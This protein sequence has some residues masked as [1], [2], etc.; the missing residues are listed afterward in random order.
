[1]LS[2]SEIKTLPDFSNHAE[3]IPI[4]DAESGLEA[5][6]A[7]F[8]HRGT[9][10][11]LGATRW[12]PYEQ[13]S[14]AASDALRLAKTMACKAVMAET[15][16]GGAKAV[17]RATTNDP[18]KRAAQLRAYARAVQSLGGQ[19][20]TGTDVGVSDADLDILM[21]ETSFIIG[22]GVASAYYTSVGVFLTIEHLMSEKKGESLRG[23]RVAIQGLG[24]TGEELARLLLKAGVIVYGT[25]ISDEKCTAVKKQLPDVH[26]VA[27]NELVSVPVDVFAPCGVGGALT[28]EV[29]RQ[30]TAQMVVGAANNQ[31]ADSTAD[32]ILSE[33]GIWYT[34]DFMVNAGGLLSVIDQYEHGA[35][36]DER[37]MDAV[38]KIPG[39]VGAILNMSQVS[40][41]PVGSYSELEA[42][43][44]MTA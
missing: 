18:L 15:P 24:K 20:I 31:L 10:P 30:L 13:S 34:P 9:F 11:S 5:Y 39:R 16:Y 14:D 6:I 17:I 38:K 43:R 36:S 26:I 3:I 21:A 40:G 25:D 8:N 22:K 41:S 42:L 44:K 4:S 19:F 37:I 29:V 2:I 27:P 23:K 1:M 35:A 12:W 28:P 7:I 32:T 33:R